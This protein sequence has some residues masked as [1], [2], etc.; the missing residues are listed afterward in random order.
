MP[1]KQFTDDEVISKVAADSDS[2]DDII[3]EDDW[4]PSSDIEKSDINSVHAALDLDCNHLPAV[5]GLGW[6]VRG[7]NMARGRRGQAWGANRGRKIGT[8][9]DRGDDNNRPNAAA[10]DQPYF[11]GCY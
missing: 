2:E 5:H 8:G 1:R 9:R 7:Q 11:C 10:V 4:W 3:S 6:G